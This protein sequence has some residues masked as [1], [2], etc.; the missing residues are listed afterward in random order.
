MQNHVSNPLALSPLLPVRSLPWAATGSSVWQVAAWLDELICYLFGLSIAIAETSN[1]RE[2][3][4]CN[5]LQVSCC[6]RRKLRQGRPGLVWVLL[7]WFGAEE[8]GWMK[9]MA[10]PQ[11]PV[12]RR[13]VDAPILGCS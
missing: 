10:A 11:Q 2:N 6:V 3:G 8:G 5:L 12:P 4:W 9:A 1:G 7:L 13:L